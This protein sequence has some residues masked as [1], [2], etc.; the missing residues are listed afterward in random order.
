MNMFSKFKLLSYYFCLNINVTLYF[1]SNRFLVYTCQ[2]AINK[3]ELPYN[4]DTSNF[5]SSMESCCKYNME[6]KS[7]IKMV[8]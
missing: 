3:L 8:E 5:P 4:N 2:N 7:L 1:V 6:K